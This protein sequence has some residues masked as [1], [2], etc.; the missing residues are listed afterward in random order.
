[1]GLVRFK[2]SHR[3]FSRPGALAYKFGQQK[4]LK[5]HLKA[6]ALKERKNRT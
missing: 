4:L 3:D 2:G 1:M 5:N 6:T